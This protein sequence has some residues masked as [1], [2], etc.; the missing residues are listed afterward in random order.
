VKEMS[1]FKKVKAKLSQKYSTAKEERQAKQIK[2]AAL[3]KEVEEARWS[4]YRKGAVARAK[5]EGFRQAKTKSSGGLLGGIG[6]GLDF[7]NKDFGTG[8]GTTP[9]PQ[10]TSKK[11]KKKKKP[12]TTSMFDLF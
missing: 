3:H 6:A 1:L 2:Q 8:F 11:G 7:L 12:K 10:P 5:S 4:G 9:K